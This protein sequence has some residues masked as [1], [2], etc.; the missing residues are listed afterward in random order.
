M[1]TTER[2]VR[3]R[4]FLAEEK[5]ALLA[6]FVSRVL[7]WVLAWLAFRWIVH[8]TAFPIAGGDEL[9]DLLFRWD[10]NWYG[11]IAQLGYEYLPDE[12]SSVAFFPLY[13][14][15]IRAV[16]AMT[17]AQ[18]ALA[19]F[20]VSNTAL[21]GAVILLRRLAALDFPAPSRVPMRT[22]WLFLLYPVTFFYSATYT[23]S[24]FALLSVAALLA[25]RHR[26]WALAG[27]AGAL[28]TATR[29]N[30]LIILVPL[31]WEA[32]GDSRRSPA[33]G[34]VGEGVLRSRWW[35][36]MVP[37]GLVTFA[38]YLHFKFGDAFAFGH[39]QATWLRAFATPWWAVWNALRGHPPGYGALFVGAA[40]AGVILFCVACRG[41]L[42]TSY[43]L[44]AG[45]MLLIFLCD[46][47]L[48]SLPRYLSV[49]FPLH[50]GLAAATARSEGLYLAALMASTGLMAVCLVLY[51]CGYWMT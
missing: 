4:S 51:V 31:L 16:G 39:A 7:I 40:A 27:L 42:R 6:F 15:C 49:L 12:P 38:T 8:G 1:T 44:Y 17:G 47:I 25:A 19:G 50:L 23:E 32:F 5:E 21:V 34:I 11:R 2:A 28:L 45:V 14:M 13:P 26:R 33:S 29:A 18:V 24:L 41:R 3:E 35:L 36:L 37:L 10:S 9:W 20:L 30:G 43:L 46:T 48:E 22:V